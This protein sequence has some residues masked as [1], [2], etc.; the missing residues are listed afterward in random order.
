VLLLLP[1][2]V[3]CQEYAADYLPLENHASWFALLVCWGVAHLLFLRLLTRGQRYTIFE[4]II[5]WGAG[6]AVSFLLL[7]TAASG[8]RLDYASCVQAMQIAGIP[9]ALAESVMAIAA[10]RA[11]RKLKLWVDNGIKIG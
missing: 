1:L 10:S 8:S 2:V 6:G 5:G 4:L 3:A 9:I 7:A 11:A